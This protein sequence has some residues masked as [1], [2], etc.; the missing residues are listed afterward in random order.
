MPGKSVAGS[1]EFVQLLAEANDLQA[2]A[3]IVRLIL[4]ANGTVNGKG[5]KAFLI[6]LA[7]ETFGVDYYSDIVLCAWGLLNEYSTITSVDERREKFLNE[8]GYRGK[9]NTGKPLT[10][11]G[12]MSTE[13][14]LY[15]K[16]EKH[17]ENINDKRAFL[18]A[19]RA[20]YIVELPEQNDDYVQ[21]PRPSYLTS[22]PMPM[23]NLPREETPFLGR[24]GIIEEL[25][26]KFNQGGKDPA[27]LWDGW[28]WQIKYCITLRISVCFS[29][30]FNRLD[31]TK[32]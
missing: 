17:Y 32:G 28:R 7:I 2:Q 26:D 30:Y 12:L 24:E 31:R 3:G 21:L 27:A 22:G 10:V 6:H 13:L 14:I 23:N 5:A 16:I 20:K 18:K 19:A 11:R 8:S 15:E 4:G 29:L 9:R 1:S 25:A